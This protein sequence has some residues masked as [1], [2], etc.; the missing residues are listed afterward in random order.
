MASAPIGDPPH[1]AGW[2]LE[3]PDP[4]FDEDGDIRM[5][6]ADAVSSMANARRI[7]GS[8]RAERLVS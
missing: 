4:G 8:N 6:E 5:V 2:W 7:G 1:L 3:K